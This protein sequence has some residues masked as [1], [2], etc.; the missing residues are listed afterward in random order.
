[1][2][3]RVAG[4]V[5]FEAELTLVQKCE[6]RTQIERSRHEAGGGAQI[7]PFRG[8]VTHQTWLRLGASV[9]LPTRAGRGKTTRCV[10]RQVV[11]PR[12]P[13]ARCVHP[14]G[15]ILASD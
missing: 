15:L 3:T 8:Q 12:A 1:M 10:C 7:S 14:E 2:L 4:K 11:V 6:P 13:L 9:P 5:V